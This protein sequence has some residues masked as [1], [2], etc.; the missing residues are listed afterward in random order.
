VVGINTT[1][2]GEEYFTNQQLAN[3]LLGLRSNLSGSESTIHNYYYDSREITNV[4]GDGADMPPGHNPE[5]PIDYLY[6]FNNMRSSAVEPS[7][8]KLSLWNP[9][10]DYIN[11]SGQH[12]DG[13]EANGHITPYGFNG[14]FTDQKNGS[15]I[16]NGGMFLYSKSGI[17]PGNDALNS[18][19]VKNMLEIGPNLEV[20][21]IIAG[22]YDPLNPT[23]STP[24]GIE[25]NGLYEKWVEDG[26]SVK[27]DHAALVGKINDFI[28]QLTGIYGQT[29][30]NALVSGAIDKDSTEVIFNNL[31]MTVE[32]IEDVTLAIVSLMVSIIVV[33]ITIMLMN[34]A[35]KLAA[36]L[37]ALGYTDRENATSFL[38]IYAPVI[39]LGLLLAIPL[40]FGVVLA[41][42]AVIF[43]GTNI[44]LAA[45]IQ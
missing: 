2:E 30:V 22:F 27:A 32:Q 26:V 37:K 39:I 18:D 13:P 5:R 3:S 34:D 6:D 10:Y 38:S 28:T 1:Y 43:A 24:L 41:F 9:A 44:L 33:L 36:I 16:L 7:E 42:Q 4:A 40:S 23:K 8:E 20:A 35:K 25:I 45:N 12:V 31:S 21:S 14:V 11:G 15:A 17:Y 19:V 29:S